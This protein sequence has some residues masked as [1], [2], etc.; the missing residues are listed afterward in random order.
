MNKTKYIHIGMPK[1][2]STTIQRDFFDK[3]PEIMHLGV[4]VGSNIDYINPMIGA[5]CENHLQYSKRAAY[6]P[7]K[8]DIKK[9]FRDVFVEFQTNPSKKACGISLE[10]L[11]FTFTPDQIEIEEK[12]SRVH[13]MFGD[14]DVKIIIIVREQFKLIESLY[15]EAVKVG[16]YGAFSDYLD[17]IYLLRD[18]NF[19]LDFRYDYLFSLYSSYFGGSNI[20]V[21]PIETVRSKSGELIYSDRKNL[22]FARLSEILGVEYNHV[23]IGHYNKPLTDSELIEMIELNRSNVHG[24]GNQA[25]SRGTNFHRL[26]DYFSSELNIVVPDEKL[27]SDARIKNQNIALARENVDKQLAQG[28]KINFEY[29]PEIRT[30][31]EGLFY[32]SN[33]RLQKL[34]DFQLPDVYFENH[35]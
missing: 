13:E 4:G 15:K 22:L 5:A 21:V 11:S 17:F 8:E 32:N 24:L 19:I 6:L 3:H 26:K 20:H 2:L 31:L 30:Y 1:N 10:L 34:L 25:F 16:Y 12:V 33:L 7:V 35:S 9:S 23:E 18:R 14:G 29:P 28:R 27:Y